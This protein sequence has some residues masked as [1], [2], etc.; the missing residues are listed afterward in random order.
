LRIFDGQRFSAR[1]SSSGIPAHPPIEDSGSCRKQSQP[2]LDDGPQI[3]ANKLSPIAGAKAFPHRQTEAPHT[4]TLAFI[5]RSLPNLTSARTPRQRMESKCIKRGLNGHFSLPNG[6]LPRPRDPPQ[7]NP[8]SLFRPP[9]SASQHL[10]TP[11]LP[12]AGRP[13]LATKFLLA[14][15][16]SASPPPLQGS[17]SSPSGSNASADLFLARTCSILSKCGIF[18]PPANPIKTS[19]RKAKS[20]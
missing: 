17:P 9:A 18:L 19:K 13:S 4:S 20:A 7:R 15:A 11:I 16:S 1:L 2:S 14:R 5:A 6:I 12:A 10:P 3:H 8:H